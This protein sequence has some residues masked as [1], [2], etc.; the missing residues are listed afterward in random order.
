MHESYVHTKLNQPSCDPAFVQ[1]M[2]RVAVSGHALGGLLGCRAMHGACM[3]HAQVPFHHIL[4][5]NFM[6]NIMQIG[7]NVQ[8]G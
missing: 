7:P 1:R 8:I 6:Y 4:I 2:Y 5:Y 3:A